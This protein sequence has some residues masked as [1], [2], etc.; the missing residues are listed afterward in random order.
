MVEMAGMSRHVAF[1]EQA[2]SNGWRPDMIVHLPNAGILPVDS[3][4]PLDS[5]LEAMECGDE[6]SRKEKLGHFAKAMRGRVRELGLKKY[7]EQFD[8]TPEF[9]AMFVPNEAC[10]GAAF[11]IDPGLLE[12]AV[13][14]HVLITTPVTLIALLKSVA[15]GW[16]QHRMN[17]NA[18]QI[19]EQGKDFYKRIEKF[20]SHLADLRKH[21]NHTVASYNRTVGSLERRLLPVARRFQELGAGASEPSP[22]DSI[23]T[24]T[25]STPDLEGEK[26]CGQGNVPK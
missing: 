21:I 2:S 9:V 4:A 7:W 19:A 1:T 13:E 14:R 18:R 12:Y 11:D 23:N 20:I 16:R 26:K 5:Y 8:E 17:E 10:L 6:K 25:A 22:P 24:Y 15:Y 3:K